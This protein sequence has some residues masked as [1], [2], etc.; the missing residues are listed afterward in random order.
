MITQFGQES[1][2]LVV[3]AQKG[4]NVLEH[5]GGPTGR[6]NNPEAEARIGKLLSRWRA[7]GLPVI[8][9]AHDSREAAS[10]LKLSLATGAFL[11]GLEPLAGET[12]L[13][14]DVNSAFVGTRLE[15]ELRRRVI[16]RLVIVGFFTNFCIETTVRMANNL[17]FDTYLG[18]DACATTNRIGLDGEDFD[19]ELVHA[20][21]IANMHREFCTALATEQLLALTE[22]PLSDLSRQQGN[23]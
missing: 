15:I 1:A 19:P 11:S 12:V 4:V 18:R 23:E 3:D 2:L 21:S 5:W 22:G 10:P 16:H 20:L 7:A 9:T 8:F 14:K 13:R 17:G 6:R